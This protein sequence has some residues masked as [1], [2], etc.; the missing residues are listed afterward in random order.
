MNHNT[1]SK[2][3]IQHALPYFKD[4]R[5]VTVESSLKSTVQEIATKQLDLSGLN[6]LRDRFEGV[7]FLNGLMLKAAA[8][9]CIKKQLKGTELNLEVSFERSIRDWTVFQMH[10]SKY[11]IIPFY[12]GELPIVTIECEEILL[13]SAVKSDFKSAIFCG[14]LLDFD[15]NDESIFSRVHGVNQ[16]KQRKFIGFNRLVVPTIFNQLNQ[17]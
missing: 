13:F 8:V 2:E 16:S 3:F 5:L 6:Q 9:T 4:K 11:R 1:P 10:N 14:A 15:F 12:F 17:Y 7:E